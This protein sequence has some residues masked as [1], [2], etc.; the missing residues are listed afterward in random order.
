[1]IIKENLCKENYKFEVEKTQ[2]DWESIVIYF[3][4]EKV[5]GK[6]I[7]FS[8]I[9]ESGDLTQC[10][11][12]M[13]NLTTELWNDNYPNVR[14]IN[15]D[16]KYIKSFFIPDDGHEY[17]IHFYCGELG[18]TRDNSGKFKDFQ[19]VEGEEP[20]NIYIPPA[21]NA[22]NKPFYI[23]GGTARSKVSNFQHLCQ[24]GGLC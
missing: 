14:N 17:R 1:M 11:I 24:G 23:G 18:H 6:T 3:D 10:G 5:R 20:N 12:G 19:I 22:E 7:T 16:N 8:C 4:Y 21:T 15:E 2:S 13:R 9:Q